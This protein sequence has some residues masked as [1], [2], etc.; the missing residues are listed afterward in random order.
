MIW[1]KTGPDTKADKYKAVLT[2][3]QNVTRSCHGIIP[4]LLYNA[5][6]HATNST[7]TF[8]GGSFS[9][10]T[11]FSIKIIVHYMLYPVIPECYCNTAL[12]LGV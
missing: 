6:Q 3:K 1:R 2:D 4:S 9:I 7:N 5:C 12:A 11:C 10:I 8:T